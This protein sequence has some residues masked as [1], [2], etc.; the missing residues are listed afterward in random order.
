MKI[1]DV[2]LTLFEWRDI[3]PTTYGQM[4]R[5]AGTSQ[6]GLLTL[7]TEKATMDVPSPAAGRISK[8]HVG[9]G[10]R[11]SAGDLVATV[12]SAAGAAAPPSAST[13]PTRRSRSSRS[14]SSR[15][16]SRIVVTG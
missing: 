9:K 13:A 12:E 8:L 1:T 6:L 11:V 4:S 10:S 2:S 14:A 3:P 16:A 5:A 7:E 15:R